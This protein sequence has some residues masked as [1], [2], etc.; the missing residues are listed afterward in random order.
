MSATPSSVKKVLGSCVNPSCQYFS[1]MAEK[2]PLKCS[3]CKS[4]KYCNQK[5]QRAHWPQHKEYCKIWAASSAS[6][7]EVPVAQIKLKMAHLIWLVRGMTEYVDYMFNEYRLHRSEA[8]E[9]RRGF[10][11]F[12]FDRWEQ[13]YAAIDFV[14]SLPVFSEADFFA[15]PGTPSHAGFIEDGAEVS[16]KIHLRRVTPDRAL[17]FMKVVD[18]FM[19]F[20]TDDTR[21]NLQRALDLTEKTDNVF[22]MSVTVRLEGTY[23]THMYDFYY[24]NLS[25][26]PAGL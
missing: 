22:I 25:W 14:E 9:A 12:H 11:E 13:L 19:H 1:M 2:A 20:T 21:P 17:K 23:S 15:M 7:G 10:M 16:Q 5:C 8:L 24:K 18:S 4:A 26:K 3:K 6:N